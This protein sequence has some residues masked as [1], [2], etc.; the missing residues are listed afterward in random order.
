MNSVSGYAALA[1]F[2]LCGL[3]S[4]RAWAADITTAY[5]GSV[6]LRV[7]LTDSP[8]KIFRVEETIPVKPGPLT[9]YYPKWI[10]GEH[11]PSGPL[12][13]LAGIAFTAGGKPLP[14]RRDLT[15]LSPPH[16]DLP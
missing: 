4:C 13:N 7:D 9:L 15:D 12:A 14:S 16:P 8:R 2:V 6:V 1:L 5:P 3:W 11:S 10:P